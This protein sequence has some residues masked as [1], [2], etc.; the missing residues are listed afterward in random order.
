[1]TSEKKNEIGADGSNG[2][3]RKIRKAAAVALRDQ[4]NCV[5]P[6]GVCCVYEASAELGHPIQSFFSIFFAREN[7]CNPTRNLTGKIIVK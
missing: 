6:I 3:V 1:M 2:R 7:R 4:T 5:Q